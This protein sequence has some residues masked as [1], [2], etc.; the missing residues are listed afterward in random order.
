MFF[1]FDLAQTHVRVLSVWLP[2][3]PYPCPLVLLSG[4]VLVADTLLASAGSDR[5][6]VVTRVATG[7]E[8]AVFSDFG[9]TLTLDFHPKERYVLCYSGCVVCRVLCVNRSQM[10]STICLCC[11][12]FLVVSRSNIDLR[13]HCR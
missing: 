3:L 10:L 5:R 9:P 13:P 6:I 1:A 12:V 11:N 7:E 8:V 4:C 2:T